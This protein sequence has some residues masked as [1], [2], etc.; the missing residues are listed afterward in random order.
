MAKPASAR[1]I[2][3]MTTLMEKAAATIK[4]EEDIK[5]P[6]KMKAIIKE[7]VRSPYLVIINSIRI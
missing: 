1:H 2:A 4:R 5:A 3:M 7:E 6:P